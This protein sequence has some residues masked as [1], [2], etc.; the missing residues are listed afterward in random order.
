[1]AKFYITTP[2]YYVN[3]KPHVGHAYTTL[4]ADV[5]TRYQQKKIGKDNVFFLT[6]ADEHGVH[7]ERAAREASKKPKEFCDA[8][9]PLFKKTWGMLN[10]EYSHF[11][12]TTDSYHEK[13]VQEFIEQLKNKGALYEAEYRGLYCE[14]CENFI[15]EKELDESG[16]CP[17]HKK[18]PQKISEKNWFF[19]LSKYIPAIKKLIENETLEIAPDTRKSEV[20][21]LIKQGMGDFSVSRPSVSW[22]IPLPWDKS[23][24]IYVWVEALLNYWTALHS[25]SNYKLQITNFG[26]LMRSWLERILLNFT[27]SIGQPCFLRT[28]TAINKDCR[29]K[30]SVMVFSRLMEK[31]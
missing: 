6:G 7:I 4:A 8:I 14:N 27:A 12:R 5:I 19:A 23:Q 31:K 9:V 16:I 25:H 30:S 28:M 29:K 22:G 10:I 13:G 21:G 24:T 17:V 15:T 2:I 26:R 11:I 20:L 1:M 18:P 3:A